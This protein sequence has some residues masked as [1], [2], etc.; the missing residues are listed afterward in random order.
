[1]SKTADEAHTVP[2]SPGV[3]ASADGHRCVQ[4]RSLDRVKHAAVDLRNRCKDHAHSRVKTLYITTATNESLCDGGRHHFVHTSVEE[5]RGH[6]ATCVA[7]VLPR[8][9]HSGALENTRLGSC[10]ERQ[11][12]PKLMDAFATGKWKPSILV[13]IVYGRSIRKSTAIIQTRK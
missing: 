11:L 9:M 10:F 1:M 7:Q 12:W 13:M 5:R 2:V 4:A 6:H 8:F 3:S